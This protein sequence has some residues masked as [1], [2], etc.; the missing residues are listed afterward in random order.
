MRVFRISSR[1]Q[2]REFLPSCRAARGLVRRAQQLDQLQQHAARARWL[3]VDQADD[4]GEG[5][6]QEVRLDLRLQRLQAG[7]DGLPLHLGAAPRSRRLGL[8]FGVAARLAR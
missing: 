7:R 3:A 4:V 1:R 6:E 2:Q 8:R 5:V